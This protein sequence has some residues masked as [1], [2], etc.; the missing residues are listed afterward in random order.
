MHVPLS[1][2]TGQDMPAPVKR[3]TALPV[4]ARTYVGMGLTLVH[5]D[6]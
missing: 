1:T 4:S 5:G 6:C 3:K 2:S